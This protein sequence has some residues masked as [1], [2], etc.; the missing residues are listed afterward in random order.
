VNDFWHYLVESYAIAPSKEDDGFLDA[1]YGK[2]ER[3]QFGPRV[4]T[5]AQRYLAAVKTLAT[6]A[7]CTNEFLSAATI[8]DRVLMQK[9]LPKLHGNRSQVGKV[10]NDLVVLARDGNYERA[11]AKLTSMANDLQ[12]PGFTSYFA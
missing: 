12:S 5:E 11:R 4:T 8:R 3:F 1:V 9:I 6:V 10:V 7:T 2:L